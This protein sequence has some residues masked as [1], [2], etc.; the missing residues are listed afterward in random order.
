M[1]DENDLDDLGE[2]SPELHQKAIKDIRERIE[3]EVCYTR[4]FIVVLA[5]HNDAAKNN[6]T[7]IN[8]RKGLPISGYLYDSQSDTCHIECHDY[9]PLGYIPV[10]FYHT[11]P[12]VGNWKQRMPMPEV[13]LRRYMTRNQKDDLRRFKATYKNGQYTIHFMQIIDCL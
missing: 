6:L 9:V 11:M 8:C 1:N 2:H 12:G 4:T 5:I 7:T 10:S 3:F 13:V